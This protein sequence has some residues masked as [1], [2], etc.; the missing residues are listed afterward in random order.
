MGSVKDLTINTKPTENE[1]GVGVFS[2]SDRYSVFDWGEMP[3]EI[4]NKGAAL[5]TMASLNFELIDKKIAKSHYCGIFDK[6]G[7]PTSIERIS[8]PSNKMLVKLANVIKPLFLDGEYNY[9]EFFPEHRRVNNFVVPLEVIYRRGVPEGSSLLKKLRQLDSEGKEK[10]LE[11][12]LD[13][14]GLS[15]MPSPGDMFP[16]PVYNFTTKFEKKDRNLTDEEA[17]VISGLTISQFDE[18]KRLRNVGVD[19]IGKRTKNVG[20][21]DY[22]GKFEFVYFDGKIMF[23]DVFGTFDENRFLFNGKQVSKEI[24]RR[25][26]ELLQPDWV[27]DV[28]RA[29]KEAE[30]NGIEDWKSLVTTYPKPLPRELVEVVGEMYSAGANLYTGRKFF[31]A[32]PLNEV[33]NDLKDYAN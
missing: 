1:L 21:T 22:D 18:L 31:E 33:M 13:S 19:I 23:A 4:P 2:F 30:K 9:L 6:S 12:L 15:K 32:R 20:L 17:Y 29:K 3:D 26:H 8:S 10:E 5:C 25:A 7:Y 27:R 11:E 14:I 24:L 28:Q 16:K